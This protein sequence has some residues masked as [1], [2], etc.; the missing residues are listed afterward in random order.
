MLKGNLEIT[1]ESAQVLA[2]FHTELM[3]VEKNTVGES[4]TSPEIHRTLLTEEI[5]ILEN[6]DLSEVESGNYFLYAAPVKYG[7]LDGAPC[8]ALLIKN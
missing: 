4:D 7:C 1:P 8:R 2:D 3:G 5:V 6:I